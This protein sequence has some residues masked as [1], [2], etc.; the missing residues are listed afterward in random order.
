MRK[1]KRRL[2]YIRGQKQRIAIAGV[3][4]MRPECIILDEPTAIW[5]LTAV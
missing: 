1:E 2:I 4:A 3:I 5:I